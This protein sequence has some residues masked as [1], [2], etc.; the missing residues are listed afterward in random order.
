[1]PRAI[2]RE[3]ECVR[4]G[5]SFEVS[6][7]NRTHCSKECSWKSKRLANKEKPDYHEKIRRDNLRKNFGISIEQYDEMLELQDGCCAICGIEES[8]LTR[9]MAVD[10][11]H[12]TGRIRGLL[13]IECNRGIGAL[14]DSVE[15]L[16]QA[17]K[18]L[19]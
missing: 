16:K 10:H 5:T 4:C 6:I 9:R 13:C 17:I 1:M 14:D 8:Q 19:E 11:D 12:E 2:D 18:Y 7:Y 3:R 15:I